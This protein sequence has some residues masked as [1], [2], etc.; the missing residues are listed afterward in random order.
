MVTAKDL[1]LVEEKVDAMQ[2]SVGS[3]RSEMNRVHERITNI[4]NSLQE[5][6]TSVENI[7]RALRHQSKG[8][9]VVIVQTPPPAAESVDKGKTSVS[10]PIT[11]GEGGAGNL[12]RKL[13]LPLF[14]GEN[15]DG[16]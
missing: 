7:A 8:E 14:D 2:D 11:L 3:V 10:S 13:E 1:Q 6:R 12:T 5:L 4:D 16:G 15:P 9:N